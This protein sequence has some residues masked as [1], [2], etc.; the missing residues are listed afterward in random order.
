M[1]DE[2]GMGMLAPAARGRGLDLS[3]DAFGWLRASDALLGDPRA[4]QARLAEDGYLFLPGALDREAVRAGRIELLERV[5]EHGALDP[6]HPLEDGVLRAD[7][8]DL[9]LWQSYPSESEVLLSVLNGDAM[10]G[11]FRDLLGG[12]VRSYD[13]VW[14][15]DQP[16]GHG[17]EPHCDLVFMGRG[18]PDVLT[19]WTPF[20][21]IAVG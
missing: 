4:L 10:M 19:C 13:F 18:T 12:E 3:E 1:T 21:D 2:G 16:R 9:G 17:V 15:R 11:L 14:L 20:G 7:A 5:R 6:D 8:D